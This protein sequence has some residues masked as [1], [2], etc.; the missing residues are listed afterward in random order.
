L[1]IPS[2][3]VVVVPNALEE[4][5]YTVA[6]FVLGACWLLFTFANIHSRFR[7]MLTLLDKAFFRGNQALVSLFVIVLAVGRLANFSYIETVVQS[8]GSRIGLYIISAYFLCWFYTFWTDQLMVKEVVKM[9]GGSEFKPLS[10]EIDPT[11]VDTEATKVFAEGRVIQAHGGARMVA[12][13][14]VEGKSHEV[15]QLYTCHEI[16]DWLV[17]YY[18]FPDEKE[19][20]RYKNCVSEIRRNIRFYLGILNIG[21]LL[22]IALSPFV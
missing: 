7:G 2:L 5:I 6:G 12:I 21:L 19:R 18:P 9:L 4:S 15:F 14:R 16:M 13:G 17:D 22:P 1:F 10:Y 8:A 3:V 20:S 11:W